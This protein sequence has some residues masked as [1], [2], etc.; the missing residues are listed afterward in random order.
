MEVANVSMTEAAVVDGAK[1]GAGA[2][3]DVAAGGGA[4]QEVG[5]GDPATDEVGVGA[6]AHDAGVGAGAADEVGV[7]VGAGEIAGEAK[8]MEPARVDLEGV[9]YVL[10]AKSDY[11]RWREAQ[12]RDTGERGRGA[13]SR[14]LRAIA[15]RLREARR[16]AALSQVDLA[17]RLG[18]S[19][20]FVSQAESGKTR[21]GDC[22][23]K[24]V[25]QA[26]GLPDDVGE[27]QA[28]DGEE[29]D[30][31]EDWAGLDPE[32]AELVRRGSERDKELK[33]KYAWWDN[34]RF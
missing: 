7:G 14:G 6:P 12:V 22:Y 25:L 3:D 26:C 31:P 21:V 15:R 4:N 20:A 28:A 34:W 32:T 10:I 2:A 8:A 33:A 9:E 23:L 13:P 1:V 27:S 16:A 30:M 17:K 5:V 18:R 11:V 19:Q 29:L 24:S